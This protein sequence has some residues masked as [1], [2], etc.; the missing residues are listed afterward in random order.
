MIRFRGIDSV[1]NKMAFIVSFI[2][3]MKSSS[4]DKNV[5]Q[6]IAANITRLSYKICKRSSSLIV[7]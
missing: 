6:Q 3:D 4:I 1:T 2:I 5:N 7:L